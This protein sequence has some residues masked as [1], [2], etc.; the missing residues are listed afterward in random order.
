MPTEHW[1]T[2]RNLWCDYCFDAA[3][4]ASFCRFVDD[5]LRGTLREHLAYVMCVAP[6]RQPS[7]AL[8]MRPR[9]DRRCFSLGLFYS[10]PSGD[11]CAVANVQQ[12][13]ARALEVCVDLGGRPYLHGCS[14]G[15][16][17]LSGE[18]ARALYGSAYD[19][20]AHAR[21]RV[22]PHGI[23]NPNGVAAASATPRATGHDAADTPRNA[24]LGGTT[25]GGTLPEGQGKGLTP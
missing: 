23:L 9:T 20:L 11:E 22:D 7:L 17:G 13:H 2:C 15:R 4:F 3:G 1:W 24:A 8:D 10:V 14:G 12:I 18:Q 6:S 16:H 25:A 19:R 21:A 5:E